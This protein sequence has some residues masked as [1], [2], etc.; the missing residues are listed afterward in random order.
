MNTLIVSP[1]LMTVLKRPSRSRRPSRTA[2]AKSAIRLVPTTCAAGSAALLATTTTRPSQRI[3][4]SA[5]IT[6]ADCACASGDSATA[7]APQRTF[8]VESRMRMS[9]NWTPGF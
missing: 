6:A 7:I 9:C 4:S 3:P 2:A 8:L 1:L 5:G